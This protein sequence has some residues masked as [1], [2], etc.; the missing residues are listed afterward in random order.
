MQSDRVQNSASDSSI[1]FKVTL[2]DMTLL[3]GRPLMLSNKSKATD[4][5]EAAQSYAVV[6]VV[7]NALF[8]FQSVENCDGS[9]SKTLHASVDNLSASANTEFDRLSPKVAPM[10]GPTAAE[11]RIVYG[12]E[13]L[14]S[15]VSQDISLDCEALK[16]SLTP[17]D[18]F[19][20]K[21]VG[22]S[23]H[24]RLQRF[25]VSNSQCQGVMRSQARRPRRVLHSLVRFQR[26]GA[27]IA[28]AIRFEIQHVSFVLLEAFRSKQGTRPL[29]DVRFSSFK[30]RFNGCMTALSGE[31]NA[32]ISVNHFNA[33]LNEW[34]S[35]IEPA[36]IDV[37][38]EQMPDELVSDSQRFIVPSSIL[39]LISF[40]AACERNDTR[41]YRYECDQC[42][43]EG[44]HQDRL[45]HTEGKIRRG[46][47]GCV[48]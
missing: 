13:N 30:G 16:A 39:V 18:A 5:A 23:I 24:Q 28:T 38:V 4:D 8:M 19:I 43:V 17:N 36:N 7:A 29:F 11:F 48:S 41:N 21:S 32:S 44:L 9:G 40:L 22:D 27:G 10:I 12:T 35:T 37:S 31:C 34:E 33:D 3:A 15:V 14:G 6:Q 1:L 2:Q 26:K 20:I 45:F 25:V 46:H 47:Q 42:H